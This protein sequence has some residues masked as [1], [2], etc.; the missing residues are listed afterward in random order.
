VSAKTKIVVLHL[1]EVIYTAIFAGLGVL[2]VILLCWMFQERDSSNELQETI[3]VPGV[4]ST[5]FQMNDSTIAV[6]VIVDENHINDISFVNLEESVTVMYPLMEPAMDDIRTQIYES[7]SLEN[8]TYEAN[9][10]YTTEVLVMA[11]DDALEQA[12]VEKTE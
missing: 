7:Q 11:I 12:R 5:S 2:L 6:E 10:Q 8:I 1:K 3:Y 9:N 4:Y